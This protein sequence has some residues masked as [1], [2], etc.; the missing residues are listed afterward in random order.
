MDRG[1]MTCI[2]FP[3]LLLILN[4]FGAAWGH[5]ADLFTCGIGGNMP[6]FLKDQKEVFTQII[7]SI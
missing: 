6:V 5:V 2:I 4:A 1:Q 7:K 3:L